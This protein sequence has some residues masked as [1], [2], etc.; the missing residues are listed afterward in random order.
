MIGGRIAVGTAAPEGA[1]VAGGGELTAGEVVATV[2]IA[3]PFDAAGVVGADVASVD[4]D[5]H[6]AIPQGPANTTVTGDAAGTTGAGVAGVLGAGD[7]VGVLDAAGALDAAG[8]VDAAGVQDAAEAVDAAG[9]QGAGAAGA[10]EAPAQPLDAPVVA[11]PPAV[12]PATPNPHAG[13]GYG[14]GT[15][16]NTLLKRLSESG[17]LYGASPHARP[18]PW[19]ALAACVVGYC[20]SDEPKMLS[21]RPMSSPHG[22][23]TPLASCERQWAAR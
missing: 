9:K 16:A 13:S 10:A 12:P 17:P 22:A 23:P 18:V 14:S 3:E 15:G 5:G 20:T 21:K 11:P 7:A 2:G 8:V 4:G 19:P 1:T 6:D